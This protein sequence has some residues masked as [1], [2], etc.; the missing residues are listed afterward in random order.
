MGYTG[1]MEIWS[2]VQ[3]MNPD[4]L[5]GPGR[6]LLAVGKPESNQIQTYLF[7][8]PDQCK[9]MEQCGTRYG[10]RIR[11]HVSVPWILIRSLIGLGSIMLS[12]SAARWES[13]TAQGL[14]RRDLP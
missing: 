4:S 7:I 10:H 8:C 1:N 12:I 14:S 9:P 2:L 11:P 3:A 5:D 6:D 13:Y